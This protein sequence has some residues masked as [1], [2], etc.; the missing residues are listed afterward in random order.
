[1]IPMIKKI[2][3]ELSAYEICSTQSMT[4]PTTLEFDWISDNFPCWKYNWIDY[5]IS[6]KQ[7]N[8][9]DYQ[10]WTV[11]EMSFELIEQQV[12]EANEYRIGKTRTRKSKGIETVEVITEKDCYWITKDKRYQEFKASFQEG[13]S[14]VYFRSPENSWLA[15]AGREGFSIIRDNKVVKTYITIMS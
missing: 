11:Y 4:G 14:L 8:I 3:P 10:G 12:Q 9:D 5:R 13:D 1:M 6:E 7:F 15:L 2:S